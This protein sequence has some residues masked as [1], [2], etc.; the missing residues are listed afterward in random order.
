[1]QSFTLTSD[2]RIESFSIRGDF[3]ADSNQIINEDIYGASFWDFIVGD[4]TRNLLNALIF[5]ARRE[6]RA[7]DLPYRCDTLLE[8]RIFVM[9]IVPLK[10]D[11]IEIEH[12]LYDREKIRRKEKNLDHPPISDL[13]R[14]SICCSFDVEGEWIDIFPNKNDDVAPKSY[15]VCKSCKRMALDL[16]SEHKPM[17]S[18]HLLRNTGLTYSPDKKSRFIL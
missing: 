16:I 18:D 15:T 3:S 6:Q 14:C 8:K 4:P 5:T 9:R 7:L 10:A 1:M 11:A 13:D 17:R 2:D 12:I